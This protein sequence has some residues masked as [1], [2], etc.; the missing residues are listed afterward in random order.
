MNLR[1]LMVL[2]ALWHASG[3][4]LHANDAKAVLQ[5]DFGQEESAPLIAV[6]GVVRDQAGPRPP[7][8]P[9]FEAN[10]TAIQ[11]QGKGSRYEIKDTGAQSPFDFTNGDAIT[12]ET[13]VKLD[14]IS[15]GQPVYL[16]GKGRTN[17]PH[18]ARNNQNWSLRV[19]GGSEGLAAQELLGACLWAGGQREQGV[20][21]VRAA[22]DARAAAGLEG[23]A[24]GRRMLAM[25]L[26]E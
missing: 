12:L 9:D 4:G 5:L 8:F 7:E 21:C 6:G 1:A 25:M 19:I 14:K 22:V 3:M 23:G 24:S 26:G 16:I 17:S 18:F 10:N 15:P 20:A 13:W 11:L 2:S